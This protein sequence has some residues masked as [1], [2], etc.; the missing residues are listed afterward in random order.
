VV[1]V[2]GTNGKGSC[3]KAL[4]QL[5][6]RDRV[7]FGAFTSPH[8][9]EYNERI[10]V[11]GRLATDAEI[12]S[13]FHAIDEA[14]GDISLTYFEFG[15]LA[16]LWVF[17]QCDLDYWLLEVGL[18][19]RLDAV[20]ILDA[21]VSVL[22][23]VDLDH[24]DW[25][26]SDREVIGKEKAG[27]LRKGQTFICAEERV[28]DSVNERAEL[29]ACDWYQI[30]REFSVTPHT[31]QGVTI[32]VT[33]RKREDHTRIELPCFQLPPNSLAAAAQV[34]CIL[35]DM[36]PDAQSLSDTQLAGRYEKLEFG[37][38]SCILDVAHN[39]HAAAL[40]AN[41]L[42]ADYGIPIPAIFACMSD[43]DIPGIVSEL[44]PHVAR[45]LCVDLPDNTRAARAD[46]LVDMCQEGGK[47]ATAHVSLNAAL[48][49][50]EASSYRGPVIIF[51]TFFIISEFKQITQ[52]KL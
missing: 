28:P 31:Q 34:Y 41:R 13:A 19:G 6:L 32:S 18:G 7:N 25:L 29:L 36:V 3:V 17:Q 16:A 44:Q 46:Q 12:C 14:R 30:G 43:K 33:D 39:P 20:N 8:I 49:E 45:W 48:Q 11:N 26:G 23:S 4:S 42:S 52:H 1:T 51:G 37:A 47:Q 27:V 21:D 24:Q 22:T 38:L 50:L 10:V 5:L 35:T 15:T 9:L 40:L 2:A